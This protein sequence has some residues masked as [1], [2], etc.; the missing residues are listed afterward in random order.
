MTKDSAPPTD[1]VE[2]PERLSVV[3]VGPIFS[4]VKETDWVF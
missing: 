2:A 4:V 1:V 3:L